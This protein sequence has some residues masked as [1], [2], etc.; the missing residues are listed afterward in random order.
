MAIDRNTGSRRVI[1]DFSNPSQG[2]GS[3]PAAMALGAIT[4]GGITLPTTPTTSTDAISN[5]DIGLG[6]KVTIVGAGF[7]TKKGSVKI[8]ANTT[9]I[10]SWSDTSVVVKLPMLKAGLYTV[11]ITPYKKT[12]INVGQLNLHAPRLSALSSS[13]G[14][15]NTKLLFTVSGQYFGIGVKPTVYLVSSKNKRTTLTVAKGNT[16]TLL[17]VSSP[18]LKA[19][20]YKVFITNRVGNSQSLGFTVY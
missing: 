15:K 19:D 1:S 16:D 6:G 11:K 12:A 2:P 10:V 17:T 13:N 20:S 18:K 9:S 5:P 7:A 14:A 8:G 3:K 4:S